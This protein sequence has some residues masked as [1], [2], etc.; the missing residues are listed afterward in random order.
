MRHLRI[1]SSKV[2]LAAAAA[3]FAAVPP[4]AVYSQAVVLTGNLEVRYDDQLRELFVQGT[5]VI[6][7]TVQVNT[8]W[9][10][11]APVNAT[12]TNG[13]LVIAA[14]VYNAGYTGGLMMNVITQLGGAK[15]DSTWKWM[16]RPPAGWEQ[17]GYS[18]TGWYAVHDLGG[19]NQTPS[20]LRDSACVHLTD[21]CPMNP[22]IATGARFLWAPE[23]LYFRRT[24]NS[25]SACSVSVWAGCRGGHTIYVDGVEVTHNDTADHST[26]GRCFLTQGQH[27]I[28]IHATTTLP[29]SDGTGG[30]LTVGVADKH[31]VTLI[32]PIIDWF[33]PTFDTIGWDTT[34][35]TVYRPVL[36]CDTNW[37]VSHIQS[38][39]WTQP[40]FND[41]SWWRAQMV[42][43]AIFPIGY[44]GTTQFPAASKTMWLPQLISFR[45]TISLSD[46]MGVARAPGASTARRISVRSGVGGITL[47]IPTAGLHGVEV[48]G[49][50]G[51]VVYRGTVS[52]SGQFRVSCAGWATGT[53]LVSIRSGLQTT[54]HAVL[55]AR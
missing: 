2:V 6:A 32:T 52:G 15:T 4:A 12:V 47:D 34:Y 24:F 53:Y 25:D 41:A 42:N 31:V 1:A 9:H 18:D 28:S 21:S 43:D 46:F 33:S 16:I 45:G 11:T 30:A 19:A 44:P 22:F 55:L 51:H 13:K 14:T 26:E 48:L 3:L 38:A 49:L 10:V 29:L 27:T 20:M 36:V 37:R 35:P 8:G 40:S 5:S 7:D 17:P 39:G 50:N 54:T 23:N